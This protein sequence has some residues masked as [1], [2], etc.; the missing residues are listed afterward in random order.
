MRDV[1]APP[2]P[3]IP[4]AEARTEA[5]PRPEALIRVRPGHGETGHESIVKL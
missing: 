2:G 4:G 1:S 5:P 3:E